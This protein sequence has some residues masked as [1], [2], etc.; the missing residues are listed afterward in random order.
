MVVVRLTIAPLEAE[1]AATV[2]C[3]ANACTEAV[4][5]IAPPPRLRISGIEYLQVR[6]EARRLMLIIQ[7]QSAVGIS[8]TVP[9]LIT[10]ALLCRTS[11]PPKALTAS[12]TSF[13][14]N[15]S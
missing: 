15:S 1:Y 11:T 10:P 9:Y 4:L 13:L 7:S 5:T 12:P 2:R 6:K 3:E 8:T 14:T